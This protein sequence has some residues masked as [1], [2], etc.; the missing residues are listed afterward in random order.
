[1]LLKKEL[2]E[3][4]EKGY[5][6]L[7]DYLSSVDREEIGKFIVSS[8]GDYHNEQNVRNRLSYPSDVSGTRVSNA[9]MVTT[10]RVTGLPA[11]SLE[12]NSAISDVVDDFQMML[13]QVNGGNLEDVIDTRCML[14][15]QTYETKSKPVPIHLDGEY[16]TT[17]GDSCRLLEGV[18]PNY[19][20]VYTVTNE[21][22]GG[23]TVFNLETEESIDLESR[24][25]DV[26]IFDNVRFLHSVKELSDPRSMFGLRNFDYEPFYYNQIS[27]ERVYHQCF[28]G[29]RKRLSTTEAK[30]KHQDFISKWI[31]KCDAQ[32]IDKAKF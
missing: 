2:K 14:N 18:I 21:G 4:E 31:T 17:V 25:G 5:I 12:S 10:G 8:R 24:P 32:G 1:M 27:G 9:Y 29:Y 7:T 6:I 3:L 22:S 23:T 20:A 30:E 26:L 13:A 16:Y 28:A 19:V 15:V 11:I